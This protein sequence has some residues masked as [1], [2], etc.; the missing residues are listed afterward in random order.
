LQE[1]EGA[2]LHRAHGVVDRAA[3]GE[4][5]DRHAGLLAARVREHVEP[6]A[7]FEREIGEH[8]V[9]RTAIDRGAR[10]VGARDVGDGVAALGQL[11]GQP[12]PQR[13]VVLDDEDVT[14]AG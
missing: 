6:G 10:L 11:R 14:E 5:Y 3:S 13:R 8:D 12:A 1:V 4:E 9:E 2:E 7:V